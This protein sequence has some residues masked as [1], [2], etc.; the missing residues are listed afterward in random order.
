[1]VRVN[2]YLGFANDPYLEIV[3]LCPDLDDVTYNKTGSC[4]WY[5]DEKTGNTHFLWHGGSLSLKEDGKGWQTQK[6]N[7]FGGLTF[8]IK[9]YDI[10]YVDL[11]G[12]WSGGAYC[13]NKHLPEP[14]IE[15]TYCEPGPSY[16][17]GY[18]TLKRVNELLKGTPW[19]AIETTRRERYWVVLTYEGEKKEHWDEELGKKLYK[20]WI[21]NG[22]TPYKTVGC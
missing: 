6:G 5:Q 20:E 16:I 3:G 22:G 21:K 1:M 4:Y 11:I 9:V 13:T 15:V 17:A 14:C 10:G 12:A 8:K 18:L 7:V 19:K 2:P